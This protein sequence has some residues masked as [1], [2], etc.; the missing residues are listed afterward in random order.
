MFRSTLIIVGYLSLFSACV[1]LSLREHTRTRLNQHVRA[2]ITP[3]KAGASP[4]SAP[5]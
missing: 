3:R 2:D 1:G 4:S 5:N